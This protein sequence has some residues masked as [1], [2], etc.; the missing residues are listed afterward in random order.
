MKLAKK[1]IGIFQS[2]FHECQHDWPEDCFVQCGNE[3][4]VL[5]PKGSYNTAFFE[6]FPKNP[7]T[8]IRGEG[9]EIPEA[10][11]NCWQHWQKILKCS[12]HEYKHHG[13]DG[14]GLC[15]H[16]GMFASNVLE[17]IAKCCKCGSKRYS[18]IDDI[19][20]CK[21]HYAETEKGK[22]H[23]KEIR[24]LKEEYERQRNEQRSL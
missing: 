18:T 8:F 7:N 23:F 12:K 1:S 4:I 10:E 20:Y 9:K 22:Q 2:E 19:H 11:N 15:I 14:H 24:E 21:I 5:T 17:P 13:L 6:A 3:G 16:C